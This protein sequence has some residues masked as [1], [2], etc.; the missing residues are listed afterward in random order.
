MSVPQC[1]LCMEN[2]GELSPALHPHLGLNAFQINHKNSNKC[3]TDGAPL[4]TGALRKD[5]KGDIYTCGVTADKVERAD[6]GVTSRYRN[7]FKD[8]VVTPPAVR[9]RL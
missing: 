7:S 1:D 2:S 9:C 3:R 4:Q 5:S 6:V 8:V